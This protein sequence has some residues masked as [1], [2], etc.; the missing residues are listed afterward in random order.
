[1]SESSPEDLAVAF[2]SFARRQREAVDDA[3]P[4][5]VSDLLSEVSGHISDAAALLGVSPDAESIAAELE[6]R[7]PEEWEEQTLASVRQHATETGRVLGKI[8]ERVEAASADDDQ[9]DDY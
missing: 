3:D 8:A 6:R 7:R 2:R 5:T 9:E 4:S 1:M